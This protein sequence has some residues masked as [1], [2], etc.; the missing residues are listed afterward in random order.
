MFGDPSRSDGT[1]IRAIRVHSSLVPYS[2]ATIV[3]FHT[4]ATAGAMARIT[5]SRQV[6]QLPFWLAHLIRVF[7]KTR[8]DVVY[9][10]NDWYGFVVYFMF[11]KIFRYKIVIESHGILSEENKTWGKPRPFVSLIGLWERFVVQTSD[12]TIA[13]SRNILN[14]YGR[15]AR[16]IE[17]IPVFLDTQTYKRSYERREELR[18][19]YGVGGHVKLVGIIGPFDSKFNESSL[20]FVY[21]N[22]DKFDG[23]IRFAL[24]GDCRTKKTDPRL[25]YLGYVRD[26]AGFLSC[27]DAVVV[28]RRL[29]TCGPPNKLLEPMSASLPV[30]TTPEGAVAVLHHLRHG[31]NIFILPEN[32]LVTALNTLL[33]N[34][35]LMREVGARARETVERYYSMKAHCA[36]LKEVLEHL[37]VQSD[38]ARSPSG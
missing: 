22:L 27:L 9:S 4:I 8:F 3:G 35:D 18:K 5:N 37:S 14:F 19:R 24:V 23:R 31:S 38:K 34:E 25:L 13:L 28:P 15:Y 17:L 30:F 29:A 26:Y 33:F 16:R 11:K 12:M 20:P 36:R 6:A 32:K 2:D 7:S 10:C 1:T 21:A